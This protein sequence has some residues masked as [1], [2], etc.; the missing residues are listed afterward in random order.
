[1][2]EIL[3]SFTTDPYQPLEKV[4]GITHSAITIMHMYNRPY[5]ILTKGG[6][7]SLVDIPLMAER[8][9]LSHYATTLTCCKE[10]DEKKW[11]PNAASHDERVAALIKAHNLGIRTWASFEPIIDPEQSLWLLEHTATIGCVDLYRIGKMNHMEPGF[12]ENE[13]YDFVRNAKIILDKYKRKYVFKDEMEPYL[14]ALV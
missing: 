2:R 14:K 9:D 6:N 12:D 7:R 5:S 3:L 1:M 8:K 4:T 10:A 11:E 13:L